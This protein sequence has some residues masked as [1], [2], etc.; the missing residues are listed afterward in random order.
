MKKYVCPS[1]CVGQSGE[2]ITKRVSFTY[3]VNILQIFFV[4]PIQCHI[5]N[6]WSRYKKN[7]LMDKPCL[8][9]LALPDT[10]LF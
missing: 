7:L 10:S 3:R 6:S 2:I 1:L 4:V 8:C 9:V 5:F